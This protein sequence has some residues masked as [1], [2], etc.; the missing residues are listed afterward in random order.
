MPGF[1]YH[2]NHAVVLLKR[3][4]ICD[5]AAVEL[6]RCEKQTLRRNP[7]R[8]HAMLLQNGKSTAGG[9]GSIETVLYLIQD[10]TTCP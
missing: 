5:E 10:H 9:A 7:R 8:P 3:D 6:L 2:L 4:L 1:E